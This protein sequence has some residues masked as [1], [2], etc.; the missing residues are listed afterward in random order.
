MYIYKYKYIYIYIYIRKRI[1]KK[2]EDYKKQI[3]FCEEFSK[4]KEMFFYVPWR[5]YRKFT[6]PKDTNSKKQK[7]LIVAIDNKLVF[8][9]YIRELCKKASQKIS[10]LSRISNQLNASEKKPFFFTL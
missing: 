8:S 4:C 7:I 2:W 6:F 9:S 5:K 3:N 1:D 10:T